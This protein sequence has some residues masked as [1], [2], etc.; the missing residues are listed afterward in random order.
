MNGDAQNNRELLAARGLSAGYGRQ[1]ILKEIDLVIRPGEFIGVAGPNGSGK[2]TLI[3][4]LTGIIKHQSGSLFYSGRPLEDCDHASLS[5]SMAVVSQ[6]RGTVIDLPVEELV[7]LGRIPY[8]RHFQWWPSRRDREVVEWALEVTGTEDL[9]S[10]NYQN[11]SGGEQQ[12]V[13]IATALA[14]EPEL[15]FLDEPTLHLDINYQI[16][17]FSLLRKLNR[18]HGCTI[19]AVLHDLNLATAFSSRIVFIR[20]GRVW[21]DGPVKDL[22]TR[23]NISELFRVRVDVMAHPENG[24]ILIFP[25]I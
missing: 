24:R 21:K 7:M 3:R 14:Q 6:S 19:L 10:K 16:E 25:E 11:L 5:R 15:L 22:V 2:T 8:F 17:I 4:A 18:E 13:L 23:E 1:V 12:R 9:R 20:E